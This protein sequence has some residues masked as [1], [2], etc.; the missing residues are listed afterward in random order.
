MGSKRDRENYF[1]MDHRQSAPVP[2]DLLRK[3]GLPA[4]AGRGLFEVASY[5]CNH[6]QRQVI[7]NPARTSNPDY[8]RGCDSY[9]CKRCAAIK[10]VTLECKPFSRIIDDV[11][12]AAERRR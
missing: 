8:C 3:A 1:M 7:M 11:L 5:S 4:G 6:C 2:D 12:T 9:L 10:S